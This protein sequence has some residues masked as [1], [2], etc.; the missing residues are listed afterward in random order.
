[1][2]PLARNRTLIVNSFSKSLALTGWRIGDL[3]DPRTVI[4]AVKALQ[5][6]T[7]FNPNVIAQ[8]AL[9][10]HLESEDTSFSNYSVTFSTRGRSGCRFSADI[11]THTRRPR[12][13]LLYPDL[14]KRQRPNPM[15]GTSTPM[16]S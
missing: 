3:A 16:T 2:A 1:M 4:G 8:H 11:N 5:S 12:R 7:T 6:H 15:A 9:V 14:T 10:H 13:V